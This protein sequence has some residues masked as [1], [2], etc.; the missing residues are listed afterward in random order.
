MPDY[1]EG[2]IAAKIK[3]IYKA[4]NLEKLAEYDCKSRNVDDMMAAVP[5]YSGLIVLFEEID[6]KKR[7]VF[8][9]YS[10]NV[11]R[12][13]R[14]YFYDIER[15]ATLKRHIGYAML[16]RD[17]YDVEILQL[18]WDYQNRRRLA[19]VDYMQIE[20]TYVAN[21]LA[22]IR[23]NISFKLVR[24]DTA[25]EA[26]D[27]AWRILATLS[28]DKTFSSGTWLGIHSPH[29]Q[30]RESGLWAMRTHRSRTVMKENEFQQLEE[31]LDRM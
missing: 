14:Q 26:A 16:N 2:D 5:R 12:R 23:E 15:N 28:R 29:S 4:F 9:G 27:M 7:I 19:N 3:R 18:W 8:I 20:R 17:N 30:V 21:V 10:E 22:Y 24:T 1:T 11:H 13:V 25:G 6:G 31:W